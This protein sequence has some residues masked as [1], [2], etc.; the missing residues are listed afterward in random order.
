MIVIRRIG[1]F[2]LGK[3]FGILYGGF[4]L[5]FGLF[6]SGINLLGILLGRGDWSSSSAASS[7]ILSIAYGLGAIICLPLAYGIG[8]FIAGILTAFLSNLAL[9]YSG[10]LEL[11]AAGLSLQAAPPKEELPKI[12]PISPLPQ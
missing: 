7:S 12:E 5:L 4:G 2:S 8:G 6:I 9:K 1:I 11:E 3:F 10:G